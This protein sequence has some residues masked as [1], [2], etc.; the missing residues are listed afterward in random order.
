MIQQ[1]L[2]YKGTWG[3]STTITNSYFSTLLDPDTTWLH[4]KKKPVI[5]CRKERKFVFFISACRTCG[6]NGECQSSKDKNVYMLTEDLALRWEPSLRT[7]AEEFASN[8]T[9]FLREFAW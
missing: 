8:S 9:S 1:A 3:N 6:T 2:G 4:K 7:I 5:T